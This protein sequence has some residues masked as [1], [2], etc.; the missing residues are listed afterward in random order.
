MVES[1]LG[2][3]QKTYADDFHVVRLN[4]F[5]HTDDKLALKEIWRQLAKDRDLDD[6]EANKV[7]FNLFFVFVSIN[8]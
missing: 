8:I 5:I 7:L 4:G 2:S 1:I 3:L 6:S